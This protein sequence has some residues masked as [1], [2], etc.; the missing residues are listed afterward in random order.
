MKRALVLCLVMSLLG[1]LVAL[2]DQPEVI[3]ITT[4]IDAEVYA[5]DGTFLFYADYG[6]VT[7][8]ARLTGAVTHYYGLAGKGHIIND[9]QGRERGQE[10]SLDPFYGVLPHRFRIEGSAELI[11][12]GD[13]TGTLEGC[14]PVRHDVYGTAEEVL[15]LYPW[16]AP[17]G[18]EE[19]KGWWCIGI[20]YQNFYPVHP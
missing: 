19:G 6:P 3:L 16:A 10:F 5:L 2:A 7:W 20:E 8:P 14:C 13:G 1:C 18:S 11:L 4:Y 15:P 17:Q 12:L 9:G